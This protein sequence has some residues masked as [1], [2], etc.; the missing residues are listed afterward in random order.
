[1]RTF[2]V[3]VNDDIELNP[4]TALSEFSFISGLKEIEDS[5]DIM[6]TDI[7]DFTL[8]QCFTIGKTYQLSHFGLVDDN[9]TTW[10]DF[11]RQRGKN[12]FDKARQHFEK[13]LIFI[14]LKEK[15]IVFQD[16]K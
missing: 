16:G 11:L 15:S 14:K 7:E 9:G 5:V 10:K 2:I 3:R 8:E 1:M 6:V 4:E 12:L 13:D